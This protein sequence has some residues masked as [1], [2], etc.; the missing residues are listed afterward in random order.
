MRQ[1]SISPKS[2][3]E[4]AVRDIRRQTCK[5][6]SA[7]EKIRIVLSG[8][9]GEDRL[10]KLCRREMRD[11]KEV[12]GNLTLV[13]AASGCDRVNVTHKPRL[14]SDDGSSYIAG[15]LT[16][17]LE[18]KGNN[19]TVALRMGGEERSRALRI[20]FLAALTAL[21]MASF[22]QAA[23][24]GCAELLRVEIEDPKKTPLLA[25]SDC[26]VSA[27][28][29][30]SDRTAR[31]I[32]RLK[33]PAANVWRAALAPKGELSAALQGGKLALRPNAD[34]LPKASLR[35]F[36]SAGDASNHAWLWDASTASLQID[37]EDPAFGAADVRCPMPERGGPL[38]W[39]D[40]LEVPPGALIAP[41]VYWT[42]RPGNY[43]R[44]APTCL[45]GWSLSD[46][47]PAVVH[48]G[49]GLVITAPAAPEGM[50]FEISARIA[51]QSRDITASGSVRVTDPASHPLAGTWAEV[52][53]KSCRGGAWR[54]PTEPIGELVFKADGTFTLVR[55]PFERYFDY[56][57][58]YR[59]AAVSSELTLK[60]TGGNRIPSE[61]SAKGKARVMPSG[62]LLL[63]DLPPWSAEAGGAVCSRRFQR[64]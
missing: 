41:S 61:R 3:A 42:T 12:V 5:Q 23:M 34:S 47:A 22:P 46:G 45:T 29:D 58:T 40:T 37:P 10:A 35:S 26:D 19:V 49:L 30:G 1:K 18:A 25:L 11:L 21:A 56:W 59:H 27:H 52:Q 32:L 48:A 31:V 36:H 57:G 2:G 53:E 16:E 9:R 7:E 55:V 33:E 24:A 39:L 38:L 51:G 28:F 13:L 8:L 62:E 6:Y 54:K 14:L 63:E 15:D 50:K 4:Q 20:C 43:N 17:W 64:Q 60:I 44:I